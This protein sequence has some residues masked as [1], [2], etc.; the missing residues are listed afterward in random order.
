MSFSLIINMKK[1]AYFTIGFLIIV[2]IWTILSYTFSNIIVPYPWPVFKKTVDFLSSFYIYK[3]LALTILRTLFGFILALFVG[4]V[5][6]IITGLFKQIEKSFF[7]PVVLLQ[8]APPILWVIPLMLI[9]GTEGAAPTAVVFFVVLPLVVLNIQEGTRAIDKNKWDMFHVYANSINLKVSELILP[10][11]APYFK[12]IFVLGSILAFKSSIIGEWFGAKD[13]IGRIINEYFYTFNMLSFY[14]VALIFLIMV[15]IL[16]FLTKLFANNIFKRRNTIYGKNKNRYLI[17][18]DKNYSKSILEVK[19][20]IFCYGKKKILDNINLSSLN[21]ETMVLTGKSGCGK[22]TFAKL[23]VGL[24][25]PTGGTVSVPENPCLIFQDDI[26]LDH[27]D[28]VGN[29]LLPVKWKK[30]NISKDEVND[31]LNKCGLLNYTQLFPDQLSGGMKKRLTFAR[32]LLLEPDFIIL[33]E[34][35]T[36][37]HKDARRE[38]WDLFFELFSSKKISSIIVTHYPEEL[39]E[40]KVSYYRLEGGIIAKT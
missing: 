30:R 10:S 31:V 24:L 2:I 18:K 33:D 37:L 32:A 35:F 21:F 34:P 36:N 13:G 6:G 3:H 14:S 26:F 4:T 11:L 7:L 27:L 20:L 39:S 19:D 38:L 29:A 25:K 12:S 22:T 8:G 40:R 28:V 23:A 15:G 5:L 16:A 9:L 1:V 17:Q